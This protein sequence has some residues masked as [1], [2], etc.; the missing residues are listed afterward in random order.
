MCSFLK[1]EVCLRIVFRDSNKVYLRHAEVMSKS[2]E[3]F[4]LVFL[5]VEFMFK[6]I[7]NCFLEKCIDI[8]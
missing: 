3:R 7:A 5:I 1:C 4:D 2:A 6:I 8:F